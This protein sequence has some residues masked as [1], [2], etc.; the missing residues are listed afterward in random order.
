MKF[1]IEGR[2]VR[3]TSFIDS[4]SLAFESEASSIL[5]DASCTQTLSYLQHSKKAFYL[6]QIR[7]ADGVPAMQ[8]CIYLG[9]SKM[10]PGFNMASVPNFHRAINGIEEEFGLR[11][12][13]DLCK[14]IPGVMTLRLQPLRFDPLELMNFQAR[15][16]RQ[17]FDITNPISPVRTLL[18]DLRP[19]S[20]ELYSSLPQKIRAKFRHP[21]KEKITLREL[22]D[23]AYIEA[24]RNTTSASFQRSKNHQAVGYDFE[25]VFSLA[26]EKPD[27]ARIIGL[28]FKD[29]SDETP[30]HLKAYVIGLRN[31]K[32][33]EYSSAG[34]LQD[35]ELRSMP[36][37]Y[38][39]LWE[40]IN[41]ARSS[42]CERMDL[43]GITD[44][45]PTD[46]LLHVS[47]FKRTLS[48]HE[49]ETGREMIKVIR[50]LRYLVYRTLKQKEFNKPMGLY[51]NDH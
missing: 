4:E 18:L 14:K 15:A 33:A 48:T 40:L 9:K 22:T 3:F 13:Q 38:F 5:S 7:S 17:G 49:L 43:G 28:F 39:L 29:H 41:W 37:N 10:P 23:P 16:L 30:E 26:K 19:T 51:A 34:S 25:T 6:L 45:A 27:Q 47:R 50:P 46:P 42:G 11:V 24:C 32:Y 21:G 1:T 31:G 8:A 44:G 20:E 2:T 12:L 35:P 36:F